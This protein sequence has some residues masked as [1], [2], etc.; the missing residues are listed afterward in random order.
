[1]EAR[2]INDMW[3][4]LLTFTNHMRNTS[5]AYANVGHHTLSSILRL[6]H[7]E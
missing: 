3:I 6:V 5:L 4:G 7:S 1:M 2:L